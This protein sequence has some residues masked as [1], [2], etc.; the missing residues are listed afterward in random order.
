MSFQHELNDSI[1][2]QVQ[3]LVTRQTESLF[4]LMVENIADLASTLDNPL[5]EIIIAVNVI[6]RDQN[7]ECIYTA[8]NTYAVETNG[9]H[10]RLSN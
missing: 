5:D 4:E 6:T 10:Q 2:E 7:G 3:D 1:G 8:F 9:D